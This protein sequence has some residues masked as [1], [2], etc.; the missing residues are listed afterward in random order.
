ME[1]DLQEEVEAGVAAGWVVPV[2]VLA[3]EERVFV[4]SVGPLFLT[5]QASPVIK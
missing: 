1:Q 4:L 3:Q 5:E 2:Q